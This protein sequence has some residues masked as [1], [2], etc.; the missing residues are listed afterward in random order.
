MDPFPRMHMSYVR[1]FYSFYFFTKEI[2]VF[3]YMQAILNH[4]DDITFSI[5]P[6]YNARLL[7][8]SHK[9]LGNQVKVRYD[10]I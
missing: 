7:I 6:K 1:F 4:S 8:E 3:K 10:N 5:Q 9:Y 2:S